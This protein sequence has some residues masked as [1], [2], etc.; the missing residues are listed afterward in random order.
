MVRTPERSSRPVLPWIPLPAI[1]GFILLGAGGSVL[2]TFSTFSFAERGP[3]TKAT[4]SRTAYEA[5]AVPFDSHP[6]S[7]AER[8][9]SISR[10]LTAT[11]AE[12]R[13][14]EIDEPKRD[15]KIPEPVLLAHSDRQLRG[16]NGFG[17]MAGPNSYLT[18][19]GTNF[20]IAAQSAP[21]GFAAP[22]SET[23]SMAPVPEASTW[24]CGGALFLLV[25]ARGLRARLRRKHRREF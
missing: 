5:R 21:V 3:S 8:A 15:S 13:R 25:G 1:L 18:V 7:P 10:A 11:Q 2:L 23:L 12:V 16:F 6:E 17:N 20:G 22:D 4:G 24:L 14:A 9:T 19:N